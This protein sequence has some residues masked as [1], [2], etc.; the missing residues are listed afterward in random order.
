MAAFLPLLL[1]ALVAL[2]A[3]RGRGM[4]PPRGLPQALAH[5]PKA[6]PAAP[7]PA[8]AE[9]PADG[10]APSPR[11]P[12]AAPANA[13]DTP[14]AAPANARDTPAEAPSADATPPSDDAATPLASGAAEASGG[15][16][17]AVERVSLGAGA[18]LLVPASLA[19]EEGPYDLIV[20]FHGV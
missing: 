4:T 17:G 11:D 20:H 1:L 15:P 18:F 10:P 3:P 14:T 2:W 12:A 7:T 5:A 13:R 19:P 9:R 8:G 6:P 16:P